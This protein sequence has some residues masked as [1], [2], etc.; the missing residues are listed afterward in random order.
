MHIRVCVFLFSF[1][2]CIHQTVSSTGSISPAD[3]T[4]FPRLRWF[5]WHLFSF[6]P[7]SS[8]RFCS[9]WIAIGIVSLS[10]TRGRF[11]GLCRRVDFQRG[12]NDVDTLSLKV[13]YK[14]TFPFKLFLYHP[15]SVPFIVLE[16]RDTNNNNGTCT[17]DIFFLFCLYYLKAFHDFHHLV[18][19]GKMTNQIIAS[20][21]SNL[22]TSRDFCLHSRIYI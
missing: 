5:N 16:R 20:I 18:D 17:R 1:F 14:Q 7:L 15:I 4:K 10:D 6:Y 9:Y 12:R 11:F 21:R 2:L 13:I 3:E 22:S 19:N 8:S